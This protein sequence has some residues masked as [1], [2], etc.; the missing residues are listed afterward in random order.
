MEFNNLKAALFV[1]FPDRTGGVEYGL[2]ALLLDAADTWVDYVAEPPIGE[3]E[4][5]NIRQSSPSA[6]KRVDR[7]I[8]SI[9]RR[10]T[11]TEGATREGSLLQ[12]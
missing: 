4:A 11:L 9:G 3:D 2:G 10:C 7:F 8:D 5:F 12:L 1:V 6:P